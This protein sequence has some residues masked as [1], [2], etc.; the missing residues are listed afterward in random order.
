VPLTPGARVPGVAN[1]FGRVELEAALMRDLLAHAC[2]RFS[3]PF[4]PI[5]EPTVRTQAY[6]LLDL[7]ATMRLPWIGADLDLE[8][9]NALDARYP[10][11]RASGFVNPGAPR[12]LRAGLRLGGGAGVGPLHTGH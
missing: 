6:G 2:W 3:G 10:E 9:Q 8:L 7:G 4:A 12:V 5:G 1:W 11:I